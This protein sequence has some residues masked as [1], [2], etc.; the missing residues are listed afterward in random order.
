MTGGNDRVWVPAMFIGGIVIPI[1]ILIIVL[2][3]MK[4][5]V[6]S[7]YTTMNPGD[8]VGISIVCCGVFS[9]FCLLIFCYAEKW[10]EEH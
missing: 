1:F 8:L 6:I 2:G 4:D 10:N 9:L 3:Y 5:T 7:I